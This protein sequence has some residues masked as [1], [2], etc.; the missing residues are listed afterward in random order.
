MKKKVFG[1]IA[2]ASLIAGAI[3]AT[4]SSHREAPMIAEDQF[5]D[6]TDVYAFISPSDSN[7]LVMVA[8]YVPLLL[9]QSG[10]N[11]YK[12]AEDAYYDINIDNDGDA[13]TDITYRYEFDNDLKNGNTFLYNVGPV[14]SITSPNLNVTQSYTLWKI[15]NGK[16]TKVMEKVPV[17][18]W[19]VGKRSFPNYEQVIPKNNPKQ[20]DLKREDLISVLRRVAVLADNVTRQVKMTLKPERVEFSVS[21]ADVGEAK[22]ELG[23]EY[24]GEQLEIG[25]NAN[26]LL[27]ALRT[28]T[29]D[30]V[31]MS[32]NTPTSPGVLTPVDGDK[33]EE[34]VCLV[35]PL[36]LAEA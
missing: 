13:K 22:E 18:P 30:M 20:I 17:A 14:D 12:F 1:Y 11:F 9:P 29:T 35:M 34:L 23:V 8:D 26:Y 25:Y 16:K 19:N 2:G 5:V 28:M 24:R 6:N 4:A 21:T 10:P 3:T 36:R 15:A 31:R 7:K 33:D 27:E 32:L